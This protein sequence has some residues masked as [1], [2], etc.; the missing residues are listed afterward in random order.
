KYIRE[1]VWPSAAMKKITGDVDVTEQDIQ[2]GYQANYGPKAEVRAIVLDS[3]RRAQ[4]VWE[5]ATKNPKV[6]FF[7]QLAEQYSME[8][9]SRSNQGRV[10][11]IRQHGGQPELEKEAFSLKPG[12]I[13]GIIQVANNYV[14]L[15]LENFTKPMQGLSMQEARPYI[16]EDVHEKKL[17]ARMSSEFDRLKDDAQIDNFLAGTSQAPK[18]R[19]SQN[20]PASSKSGNTPLPDAAV[21]AAYETSG[22]MPRSVPSNSQPRPAMPSPNDAAPQRSAA[23]SG[24]QR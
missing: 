17:R 16:Y 19:I 23:V 10:P 7:G 12:E 4:E 3:Q 14:I 21:P 1:A 5:K 15:Y 9:S 13:S 2:F 18:K 20:G 8:P 22:L 6:E 24:M 11:P